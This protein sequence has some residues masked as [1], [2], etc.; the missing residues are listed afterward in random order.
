M[1]LIILMAGV[2]VTGVCVFQF[3]RVDVDKDGLIFFLF[4]SFVSQYYMKGKCIIVMNI[5]MILFLFI[6]VLFLSLSSSSSS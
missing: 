5:I 4:R 6:V 3:F 1:T 2:S